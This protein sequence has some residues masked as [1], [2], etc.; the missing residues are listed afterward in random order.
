MA[1]DLVLALHGTRSAAG[2]AV[3]ADLVAAVA[4]GLPGTRVHLG[5]ADVLTPTLTETLAG[6]GDAVLV[7]GFLTAG[8]HVSS[9]LPAAV[10]AS[11][12]RARIAGLIG[13]GLVDAVADRLVEAGG[14]GDAV[15]LAAAGS[16]RRRSVA[17]VGRAAHALSALVGRPVVPAFLT[18]AQ[19]G[20][21]EAVAALRASGHDRIAI[22]S[23]L[24]APGV[25]ADRLHLCGAD[26]VSA[27]IGCHPLVV[28]AAIS[29]YACVVADDPYLSG[30]QATDSG[31]DLIA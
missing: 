21:A 1:P 2:Q 25:F 20:V 13:P 8:Y 28:R 10:R 19:P 12:G 27:P 4:A 26:L 6:L 14:P 5:W 11:G 15:V 3:A 9:D 31:V 7:P 18:A 30:A 17:E 16:K 22:A 23:Y 29:A 24:L